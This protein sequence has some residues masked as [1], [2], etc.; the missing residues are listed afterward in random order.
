MANYIIAST[1]DNPKLSHCQLLAE[2]AMENSPDVNVTC[3][4]KDKSEWE[5]FVDAV[6]RSYGFDQKSDPLIYTL[7]GDLIGDGERFVDHLRHTYNIHLTLTKETLKNLT[8]KNIYD[9]EER[10]RLR[11]GRTFGEQIEEKTNKKP[12]RHVQKLITDAF[13][14]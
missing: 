11:G 5:E 9:N 1:P 12:K 10:M 13:Y 6:V 7:Q 8:R 3:I 2:F 4:I 14:Q